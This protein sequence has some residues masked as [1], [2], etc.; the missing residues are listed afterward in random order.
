[1]SEIGFIS[2]FK[3]LKNLDFH[4]NS[5]LQDLTAT[6]NYLAS[7]NLNISGRIDVSGSLEQQRNVFE[8]AVQILNENFPKKHEKDESFL[9]IFGNDMSMTIRFDGNSA[10]LDKDAFLEV[11]ANY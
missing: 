5:P 4:T 7:L 1:M 10:S 9:Y 8:E 3:N 2:S 6:L 11:Q